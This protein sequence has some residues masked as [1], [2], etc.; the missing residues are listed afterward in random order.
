MPNLGMSGPDIGKNVALALMETRMEVVRLREVYREY[1]AR[2]FG[3]SKWSN[4][5]QGNLAIQTERDFRTRELLQRSGFLSLTDRR[6]LDVGCG[7]GEQLGLF[8]NW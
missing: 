3:K 6:I 1:A 5:N 4:S 8:L 2:G 7:T